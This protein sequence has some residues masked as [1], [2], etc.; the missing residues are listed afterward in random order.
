MSH[1]ALICGI[2]NER[3][4]ATAIARSLATDGW[5]LVA[6]WQDERTRGRVEKVMAGI[7]PDALTCHLDVTDADTVTAALAAASDRHGRIDGLVHAIAFGRLQDDAGGVLRVIDADRERYAEALEISAR[8]LLSLCQA[9]EPHFSSDAA[10]VA[11]T[12]LGARRAVDGYNLMGVAKAALEAEVRYLA[13]ELGPAGVRVNAV[14]AG[15]V[16]TLAASGVPGFKERLDHH[17]T[18]TP[19]RRNISAKEVANAATFLLS[20]AASGITGQI[21]HVDA[22]YSVL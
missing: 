5:T 9:C 20:P 19:L 2:A 17:A 16:R 3:S 10:V 12:Y 11:L 18:I 14:S 6:T 8:S 13:A 22:G 1:V 7:Q 21:L 15:P 4:L